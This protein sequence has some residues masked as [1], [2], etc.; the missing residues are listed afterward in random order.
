MKRALVTG[1]TGFIGRALCA[2]LRS[3]GWRIVRAVRSAPGDGDIAVSA[4]NAAGL[5]DVIRRAA[6]DTIFHLAGMTRARDAEEMYRVNVGLTAS[7]LDAVAAGPDRPAVVLAGSAAE[8]GYLPPEHLPAREAGPTHPVT[9][10]G[11]SKYAQTLLGL[12][13]ARAGCPVLVARIFN[14]VGAGMPAHLALASFA[15]QIREGASELAVGNLDVTRDFVT[16][17]AV[18]AAVVAL[19]AEPRNFGQVFNIC[20]GVEYSL[21]PLVED[22][23]RLSGQE[24]RLTIATD[25][26]R[27]GEM[28]RFVGDTSRLHAAGVTV[29]APDFSQLLPAIL[30]G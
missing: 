25:R 24:V 23:I 16:V 9:D 26:L 29:P 5:A 10:Y 4:W 11:I 6:P 3:D 13:R 12:S 15:R 7:L 14:P 2:R 28:P 1:A 18:A 21:R 22:L 27:P 30:A 8:Y 17:E 19:A 20:S